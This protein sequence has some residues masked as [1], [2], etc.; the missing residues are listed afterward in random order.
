MILDDDQALKIVKNAAN[1]PTKSWVV[2]AREQSEVLFA[3]IEGK[4]FHDLLI[5]QI[6]HVETEKKAKARRKYARNIVDFYERLMQ[7]ITNVF[8]AT[9]GSKKYNID[10][11]KDFEEFVKFIGHIKDGKSIES[12][13]QKT[14]MPLYHTDPNGLIFLEFRID[15][16]KGIK[17]VWPTYKR[18]ESIRDYIPNGQK[19]EWVLFEPKDGPNASKLWRIVDDEKDRTFMQ[20]GQTITIVGKA[21]FDHPFGN[22]PAIIISDIEDIVEGVRLSPLHKVVA[23]S[24]EYA[25]DQSVKTIYKA[26]LG[27]PI[28]WRLTSNCRT[29]TGTGKTGS[30]KGGALAACKDCNGKGVNTG[31]DVTDI[32]TVPIPKSG[33]PSLAP[34]IAGFISPDLDTLT[35]YTTEAE[36]LEILGQDTHWGTHKE[37]G[38]PETATGR[39]IDVQPVTNKLHLYSDSTEFMEQIMTEFFANFILEGKPKD[40][41][42]S[43]I[44]YG[45]RYI[46]EGPDQILI[47]YQDAKAKGENTVV[48]DRLF[49]EYLTAKYGRDIQWLRVEKVKAEVEPFLHVGLLDVNAIFGQ[50]EARRKVFFKDWWE[51]DANASIIET[52]NADKIKEQFNKDFDKSQ[53]NKGGDPPSNNQQE[54]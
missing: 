25:R 7:P 22:V 30:G 44:A 16:S 24:K 23:L 50:T 48:L 1:T 27:F 37:R 11:E 33:E 41:R 36:T 34:N 14:W 28:H 32:V 2:E 3:L 13:L 52:L 12:Y 17:K 5:E 43:E 6:D 35:Q 26:Q 45:R 39:F 54:E 38:A 4:N 19:T 15:E 20:T 53:E 21:T 49:N 18:I 40:E 10:N 46:L 9:G 31:T 29:C 47:R 8:S 51:A 42:I